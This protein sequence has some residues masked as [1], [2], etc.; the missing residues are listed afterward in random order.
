[1]EGAPKQVQDHLLDRLRVRGITAGDLA[2]LVAWINAD[3]QVP[4]GAWC[5]DFGSF[6]L[7]REGKYP[8]TF[9][10]KDQPCHGAKI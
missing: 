5:R 6:K 1:V 8:K 4:D 3:P 10:N 9:P 2:A 7:G